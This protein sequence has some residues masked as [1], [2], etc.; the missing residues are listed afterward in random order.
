MCSFGTTYGKCAFRVLLIPNLLMNET[1]RILTVYGWC[2]RSYT[3]ERQVSSC[4]CL[5][6][7]SISLTYTH[8]GTC[9][10]T[11]HRHF[12]EQNGKLD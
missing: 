12:T 1:S 2:L 6:S 5:L 3:S 8:G 10:H 9:T 11:A 7:L 4:Y